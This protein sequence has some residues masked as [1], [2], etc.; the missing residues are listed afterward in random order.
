[1]KS[2]IQSGLRKKIRFALLITIIGLLFSGLSAFPLQAEL[3]FALQFSHLLPT[4]LVDWFNEVKVAIT[5]TAEKYPLVLYGY[6][7]L[8][9]AHFLIAFAFI[10]PL[11]DP[12]KNQWVV[13]WGMISSALTI[14]MSLVVE[15][16]RN[17]P[18]FWSLIDAT[19]GAGAFL[20]LWLCNHWINQ[21][22][23][24]SNRSFYS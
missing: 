13:E 4:F 17:I 24:S 3:D 21:L 2:N 20:I 18:L 12:I 9:F 6:D 10:G 14:A 5:E 22:R 15:P 23:R 8:G 7:W 1:M 16:M 19:I 11:R